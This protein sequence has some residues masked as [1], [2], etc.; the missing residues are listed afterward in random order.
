MEESENSEDNE[1]N[2]CLYLNIKFFKK[3][4]KEKDDKNY[5]N[6]I[7]G[8]FDYGYNRHEKKPQEIKPMKIENSCFIILNYYNENNNLIE[9]KE[10][11]LDFKNDFND[12]LFYVR[13]SFKKNNFQITN[14]FKKKWKKMK[15]I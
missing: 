7:E 6:S 9:K 11:N 2:K 10:N 5:N 14:I 4:K 13:K 1:N 8:L 12:I 3:H 15:K